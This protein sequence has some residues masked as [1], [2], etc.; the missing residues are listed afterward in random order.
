[1][2]HCF[3]FL[4]PAHIPATQVIFY[5]KSDGIAPIIQGTIFVVPMVRYVIKVEIQRTDTNH[6]KWNIID[7]GINGN[8]FGKCNPDGGPDGHCTWYECAEDLI[9]AKI[10][11]SSNGTIDFA[12]KYSS[13]SSLLGLESSKCTWNNIETF[14]IARVTVF[15]VGG[16]NI[17]PSLVTK[18]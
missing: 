14:G 10:I 17:M 11:W 15:P 5:D 1:M 2:S 3:F 18:R 12:A 16:N 6:G 4:I 9:G 8:Q 13:A 7:I